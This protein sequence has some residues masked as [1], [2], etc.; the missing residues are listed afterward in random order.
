MNDAHHL[1]GPAEKKPPRWSMA[2]VI[3]TSQEAVMKLTRFQPS[4]PRLRKRPADTAPTRMAA[5]RL[6]SR[7]S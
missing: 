1:P 2:T 5:A 3:A 4:R 7:R 6:R